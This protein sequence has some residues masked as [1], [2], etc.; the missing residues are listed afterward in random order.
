[1]APTATAVAVEA[2]AMLAA[3]EH[4]EL[5]KLLVDGQGRTLYMFTRDDA[6][7]SNCS[8]GCATTWPPLLASTIDLESSGEGVS[9]DMLNAID[10]GDGTQQVTYNGHPLYTYAGDGN[11]GDAN[12]HEVGGV[13]FVVSPKGEAATA[14][15]AVAT[16]SDYSY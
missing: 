7:G 13:W 2:K 14:A 5:G 9:S 15:E 1:M 16:P 8:G 4:S 11:P 6:A 12:G 10:R 3:G